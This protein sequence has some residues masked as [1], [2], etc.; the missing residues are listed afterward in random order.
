[1]R[2]ISIYALL[3][4]LSLGSCTKEFVYN[5]TNDIKENAEQIFGLIDPNQDWRTT[6]SGTVSIT[7]DANLANISKVQILTGSPFFNKN[8]KIL[9]ETEAT[10]GQTVTLSYDAPRT[11]TQVVAACTDNNGKYYIQAFNIGDKTVSFKSSAATTRAAAITRAGAELP[12]ISL[13]F[14]SSFQS[15]NAERAKSTN[16]AYSSWKGSNW[17]N[18][19]LWQLTSSGNPNGWTVSNN[20]I[21]RNAPALSAEEEAN[22]EIIFEDALGRYEKGKAK[23]NLPIIK[24]SSRVRL[25]GNHLVSTGD[26]AITLTPVQAASTE[27]YWCDIYYYYYRTGDIPEGTSEANYI[28]TLPKFKAIDVN[29]VR[30][31][32]SAVT[33]TP[34]NDPDTKFL[35]QHEYLL[36]FYGN[37]SEF[38]SKSYSLDSYGYTT[39]GN[40]YRIYN[41]S[42]KSDA[43]PTPIPDSNHYITY[44]DQTE[45]LKDDGAV[46]IKYQLWQVFTNANDNSV[47]LYNVGSQKFFWWNNGE[48]VEVKD[49]T[50]NSLKNYT[51]YV[52][53]DAKNPFAFKDIVGKKVFILSSAKSNFIKALID[54]GRSYLY[55]GGTNVSGN[56]RDAREWTF[57]LYEEHPATAITDFD[58]PE[59]QFPDKQ[60]VPPSAK[61]ST[62]IPAGYRIGFMV[63]KD[64]GAK[65]NNNNGNNSLKG[66][67][68]GYGALNTEINSYGNFH[69]SVKDFHMDL[70]SPRMATFT[71]NNKV[72]LTFEEGTDAQFSDI[73]V[74][75]GS[76]GDTGVD[77][78]DE[79][80]EVNEFSY[81]MCFEDRPNTADYDM[82]DVVLRCTRISDTELMLSLIATGANDPVLISGIVGE[83]S[84][85]T[86]LN[87]KEVHSL[88]DVETSTF[89]NT[90]AS[91]NTLPEVSGIYRVDE[92]TTIKQF[93]S[94]IYITNTVTGRTI[95]LPATGEPPFAIIM[96][97]DFDYPQERI[98]IATAY[99]LFS[100]WVNDA[101]NYGDWPK[102]YD[103][104][105][106]YT[107]PYNNK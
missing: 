96:P 97:G 81:T 88:F 102:F 57:E 79:E 99:R 21:Y 8:A 107:N 14:K 28:K 95:G 26:A 98:S 52:T 18:D 82:N 41:H 23:N 16:N 47:M 103:K 72:Y 84:R 70:D 3:S 71:A 6:T 46:D 48:Y 29:E 2:K 13:D 65:A 85:G 60:I 44:G 62:I 32:I 94:N 93:L 38:I 61:P 9:A 34:K 90:V 50:E 27:A 20:T 69:R 106:I 66:C 54:T 75:M 73:I 39:D 100:E 33:G 17:E 56:F 83:F 91:E 10:A 105:K 55:R 104:D 80:Q 31:G 42:G 40:Y 101:T 19:R 89:V 36:P 68:Y 77:M 11:T 43:K 58:L 59:K 35:R 12:E 45:N 53:D 64:G 87:G 4:I 7:A 30:D 76:A 15:Y 22:L 24:E 74:E 37:A 51:I 63:R 86:D 78:F 1:M 25:Y 92:S 5:D 67:V 49:I